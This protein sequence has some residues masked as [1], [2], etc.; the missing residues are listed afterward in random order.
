MGEEGGQERHVVFEYILKDMSSNNC[1]KPNEPSHL[2]HKI[3]KKHAYASQCFV[4]NNRILYPS[5]PYCHFNK[6]LLNEEM[7]LLSNPPTINYCDELK[8][9]SQKNSLF[10][11]P[12]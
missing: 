11:S 2:E 7:G 4:I 8:K 3:N 9:Y 6:N 1:F 10:F 12:N 5:F